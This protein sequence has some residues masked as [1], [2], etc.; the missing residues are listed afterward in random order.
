[1]VLQV[2]NRL[3]VPGYG[4]RYPTEARTSWLL[5][6]SNYEMAV[7]PLAGG[8][9]NPKL[10]VHCRDS[11]DPMT[12]SPDELGQQAVQF[13]IE[14]AISHG[15]LILDGFNDEQ[16]DQAIQSFLRDYV[17]AIHDGAQVQGNSDYRSNLLDVGA[18][19]RDC[20]DY[21]MAALIYSTWAEHWLNFAVSCFAR[22]KHL[23]DERITQII[24]DAP[25]RAKM[26]WLLPLLGGPEIDSKH[27]TAIT[28]LSNHRNGFVHYKWK[29][30]GVDDMESTPQQLVAAV[31]GFSDTIRYLSEYEERHIFGNARAHARRFSRRKTQ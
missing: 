28:T 18:N 20:G 13:A 25:L 2:E 23:S 3:S 30:D 22:R 27:C 31:N 21:Q 26:T 1:M 9:M 15:K 17:V 29:F 16:A 4:N 24:R 14:T 10:T 11:V 5:H 19:F 12:L 6:R 8:N 7:V